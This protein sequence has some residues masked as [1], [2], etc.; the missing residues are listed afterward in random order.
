MKNATMGNPVTGG[1]INHATIMLMIND[2]A[3]ILDLNFAASKFIPELSK[4]YIT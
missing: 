3:G 1:N 2:I 4:Y